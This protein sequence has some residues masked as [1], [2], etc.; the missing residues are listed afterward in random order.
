V[1]GQGLLS[2]EALSVLAT[3]IFCAG[4]LEQSLGARNQVGRGLMNRSA[5]LQRLLELIPFNQFLGSLKV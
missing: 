2:F 3:G 1:V 4:I 5:R